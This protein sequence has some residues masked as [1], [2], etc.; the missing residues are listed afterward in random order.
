MK[1]WGMV[2]RLLLSLRDVA[3]FGFVCVALG[4]AEEEGVVC[5]TSMSSLCSMEDGGYGTLRQCL[6]YGIISYNNN[7]KREPVEWKTCGDST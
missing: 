1:C 2:S 5:A 7:R 6:R 4:V 3:V